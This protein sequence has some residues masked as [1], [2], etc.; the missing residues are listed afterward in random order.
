MAI[1]PSIPRV[2]AFI[3][4]ENLVCRYQEMLAVGREPLDGVVHRKDAIV[5][6]PNFAIP[7]FFEPVRATYYTSVQGD[8]AKVSETARVL[9]E[10]VFTHSGH[11]PL[12]PM[13]YPRVFKRPGNTKKTSIVDVQLVVDVL[14]QVYQGNV[15][16]VLLLSGDGDFRALV[17][18][19]A[20]RGRRIIVGAFSLGMHPE[21]ASRA[22]MFIDLDRVF[23]KALL[24]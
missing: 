11:G 14:S 12:K 5:W 16:T 2:M 24:A 1:T 20:N 3:D 19:V 23:L 10:T 15:D 22:D 9:R 4:G 17:E 21:V 7:M 18:E 13:L 6:H 8:E